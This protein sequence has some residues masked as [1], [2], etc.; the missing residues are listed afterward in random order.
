MG[1][2]TP[3]AIEV[4]PAPGLVIHTKTFISCSSY[5]LPERN[6]AADD[7]SS[8]DMAVQASFWIHSS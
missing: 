6:E 8:H 3:Q 2:Y 4:T 7:I 5:S 1:I